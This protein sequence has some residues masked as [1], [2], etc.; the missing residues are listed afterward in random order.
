VEED[1][2]IIFE[3]FIEQLKDIFLRMFKPDVSREI[4]VMAEGPLT[5]LT[6]VNLAA[7]PCSRDKPEHV[8]ALS[9][10]IADGT[11]LRANR[12]SLP[13]GFQISQPIP[14]SPEYKGRPI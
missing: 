13:E 5:H 12:Q 11:A 3:K 1:V 4:P 10:P 14:S 9:Y 7:V 8:H 2:G 6:V